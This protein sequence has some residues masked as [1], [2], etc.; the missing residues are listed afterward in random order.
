MPRL[1]TFTMRVAALVLV[2]AASAGCDQRLPTNN[3]GTGGGPGGGNQTGDDVTPPTVI[4]EQPPP[5]SYINIGDSVLVSVRI[6]DNQ[7]LASVELSGVSMRGSAD[8]G[9]LTIVNRFTP[10]TAPAGTTFR[11]ALTDTTIRRYMKQVTPVDTTQDS[12]VFIAIVKDAAG[13][14]DTARLRANLVA[15]PRVVFLTPIAGDSVQRGI[16]MNITMRVTSDQGISRITLRTRNS[17]AAPC[18]RSAPAIWP[19]PINDS[20]TRNYN[21]ERQVDFTHAVLVPA[22]APNA[23]TARGCIIM[24]PDAVDVNRVPGSSLPHHVLVRSSPP[25]PPLVHQEVPERAEVIDTI[26]ITA[27][28]DGIRSLGFIVRDTTGV[29]L[30]RDSVVYPT[31]YESPRRELLSLNLPPTT[32]GQRVAVVSFAYDQNGRVGYSVPATVSTPQTDPARAYVDSALIV[33]GRTYTF[34]RQGIAGDVAVDPLRGHV[35]V[36][37]TKWNRLEVWRGDLT[38]FDA[39]GVAV[40]SEPWGMVVSNDPNVLLVANSGGTNISRVDINQTDPSLIREMLAQ[41]MLTRNSYLFLVVEEVDGAT[42]KIRFSVVGPISFSDRPQYIQQAAGG[43]VYYSTK[44]TTAAPAGTIRWLDPTLPYPD[45]Q[46]IWQY[47]S[48]MSGSNTWTVANVDS[49]MVIRLPATDPRP[50]T[51]VLWDHPY[52]TASTTVLEGR[53]P[54]ISLA[55]SALGDSSDVEVVGVDPASLALTDTTFV[56]TSG[57]RVWVA[58]GEGNTGGA[59]GRIMMVKDSAGPAPGLFSPGVAVRDIIDNAAEPVYGLALDRLGKTLLV[60]GQQSYFAMVED[61]FHLRLQGKYDS[62]DVGAG[63]AFHPNADGTMSLETERVA[64]VASSNGSIE[65]VDVAYYISRGKI[66]I[67]GTLYGALRASPRF[68]TDPTNVVLK[69]FGLTPQGLVVI[70]LTAQDIKPVP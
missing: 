4:I 47:G 70:D 8:L 10:I 37:N 43:R 15:G 40:G 3:I 58:F 23:A 27:S 42:G 69:L 57:N 22:N 24:T 11:P 65:I 5:D 28:G 6:R 67:K 16:L 14:A 60:H 59:P 31:P 63:V 41:R 1:Q 56:T 51:L 39:N 55:A 64:F 19:T 29:E 13:L 35:F 17:N 61:P 46:H 53:G 32:Q 38:Q 34:P 9:N 2:L 54:S 49:V 18:P 62:F 52:G 12:V 66:N 25:P 48:A 26:I 7:N 33:H 50:D 20:I 21:G 44:P 68:P 45:P 30:R 36:S